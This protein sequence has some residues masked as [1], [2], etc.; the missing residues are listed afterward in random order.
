VPDRATEYRVM[1]IVID[2]GLRAGRA[3]SSL[4]VTRPLVARGA[5]PRFAT[6]GDRFESAAY[7]HNATDAPVHASVRVR[8][9]SEDRG[10]RELDIPARGE[11]RV[12]EVVQARGEA[13][14]E[15]R[16]EASA[17]VTIEGATE[18]ASHEAIGRVPIVPRARWLRRR[19]SSDL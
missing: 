15:V 5:F 10:V 7:I 2:E 6:E 3:G 9:G 18:A 12:M 16:F 19:C 11:A 14:I 17:E 13:P 8:V 4:V 1:A